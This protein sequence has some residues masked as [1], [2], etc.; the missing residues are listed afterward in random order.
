MPS[1]YAPCPTCHGAR[2]NA[3]TLEVEYRGH[4][5]A[6][7]LGMTV[8]RS[9]GS[10]SPT[11][12]RLLPHTL[13]IAARGRAGIFA[14]RSARHRALRRRGAADQAHHRAA[15]PQ[16]GATLYVLDEPTIGLHPAD[17][18]KLDDPVR[19]R[20]STSGNTVIVVEHEMRVVAGA[21][22]LIDVGPGAG[23]LGGRVVAYGPPAAVAAA[24][25]GSTA[26]YLAEWLAS[27]SGATERPTPTL[28][29]PARPTPA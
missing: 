13:E 12:R 21:D 26:P 29:T 5:I 10:S 11:I 15:T 18:D 7:V 2:Y 25:K 14:P 1:V 24:K 17:V 8:E 22:W 19:R 28:P 20:W 9:A 3:K 27:G 23:D 6:Q 4:N 16:R